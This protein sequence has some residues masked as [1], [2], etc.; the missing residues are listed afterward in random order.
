MRTFSPATVNP[1]RAYRVMCGLAL[2]LIFVV[3][4]GIAFCATS[5]PLS[6]QQARE[7]F[8]SANAFYRVQQY[9]KARDL[10]EKLAAGGFD[11]APVLY[12]LGT[13][14]ARLGSNTLAIAN[15]TRA[16]NLHPRDEDIRANLRFVRAKA[17]RA[18]SSDD[19]SAESVW[20]SVYGFLSA[21]E[22][23]ACIWIALMLASTGVALLM[24]SR[25]KR[26]AMAGRG[27]G[28]AGLTLA[29]I[30]AIPAATQIYHTKIVKRAVVVRSTELLSGPAL[31][32]TRVV[33]LREGQNVRQ[34]GHSS[35]GF[36]RVQTDDGMT[37]YAPEDALI[38][39]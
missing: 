18:S 2:W 33:D 28:W 31:R 11:G 27:L 16:K 29:A 7:M 37:G 1:F 5:T 38:K 9:D 13:T 19:S 17:T 26:T 39:I 35:D 23:L 8:A 24:L 32:F 22:W 4:P 25:N 21:E 15:L 14:D 36:V 6:L 30:L 3:I 10:Y 12:N 34:L 20:S